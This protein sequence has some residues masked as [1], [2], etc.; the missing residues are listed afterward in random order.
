MQPRKAGQ[1][2]KG[3]KKAATHSK[4]RR[5]LILEATAPRIVEEENY[6]SDL[7]AKVAAQLKAAGVSMEYEKRILHFVI[8]A[9]DAKY[10]PDFGKKHIIIEAKGRFGDRFGGGT[11]V[12]HRLVL[13][14]Q[15]HP[16]LD[17][18]LVFQNANL[19]IYKGS[20]TTYAKWATDHG[21]KWSDKGRVP[22]EWIE[23]LKAL[24]D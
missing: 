5:P 2:H 8:P 4:V 9:F 20:K 21:F 6:R 12:R 3:W 10:K 19:K 15:Q 16:E 14:K 13:V 1:P 7:E 17:I 24:T 18:R 23:E 22:P 11:E